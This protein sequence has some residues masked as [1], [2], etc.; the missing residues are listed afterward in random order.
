MTFTTTIRPGLVTPFDEE[1]LSDIGSGPWFN[2]KISSYQYRKYYCG[3]KTILRPSYLH[4]GISYTG[5]TTSLYWVRA[6]V[7]TI[8]SH[9]RVYQESL[10]TRYVGRDIFMHVMKTLPPI[11]VQFPSVP[12]TVWGQCTLKS[13]YSGKVL[14]IHIPP[15]VSPIWIPRGRYVLWLVAPRAWERRWQ[16]NCCNEGPR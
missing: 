11:S 14:Y 8:K 12:R 1:I 16:S 10:D 4:N 9:S 7:T 5:K 2:K 15:A 13:G 6:L 3:D